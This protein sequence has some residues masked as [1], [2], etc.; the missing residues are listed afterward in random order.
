MGSVVLSA[1]FVRATIM[2][3]AWVD[4]RGTP[5]MASTVLLAF[6]VSF[7]ANVVFAWVNATS[8]RSRGRRQE[9]RT[10]DRRDGAEQWI[11]QSVLLHQFHMFRDKTSVCSIPCGYPFHGL[12][13]F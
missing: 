1:F 12:S 4:F 13:R 6:V 11:F 5:R 7:A 2:V 9:R 3:F 8:G 10:N